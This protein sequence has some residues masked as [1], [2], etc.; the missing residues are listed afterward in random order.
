MSHGS[1]QQNACK[2]SF[3]MVCVTYSDIKQEG[4]SSNMAQSLYS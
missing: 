1:D 4:V 2:R 3:I